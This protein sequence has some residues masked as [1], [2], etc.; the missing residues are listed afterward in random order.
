MEGHKKNG[1]KIH[2]LTNPVVMQDTANLLLAAGGSAIMAQDPAEAEEITSFCQATLLN[3]GVPDEAKFKA[4]ILAGKRA[5]ALGHPVILDPVGAGASRFRRE[6][7]TELLS[8]VK[9]S[10][11]RCNQEEACTLLRINSRDGNFF[12]EEE[13]KGPVASCGAF[14]PCGSRQMDMPTQGEPVFRARK[15]PEPCPLGSLPGGIKS[16]KSQERNTEGTGG[17][18][19]QITL[20]D[21]ELMMLARQLGEA[22]S[23]TVLISG[24]KDAVSDGKHTCLIAG[25]SER[26]RRLTGSGCMLSAL[27]ALFCG[28][29]HEPYE[30]AQKAAELWKESARR[31]EMDSLGT[32]GIGSFHIRLFDAVEELCRNKI[33]KEKR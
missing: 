1:P 11:I 20:E 18:E 22:Y 30:A 4:C 10:L 17:V 12:Y 21:P 33:E 13:V 2:C 26:M 5:N 8:Q 9:I 29:G 3:T 25:G 6:G 14:D 24:K 23:C 31:A 27:C 32:V 28:Y 16:E 19:S 7:L 15:W